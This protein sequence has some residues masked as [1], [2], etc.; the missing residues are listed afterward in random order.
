MTLRSL[1]FV[2]KDLLLDQGLLI[3]DYLMIE[4]DILEDGQALIKKFVSTGENEILDAM[5]MAFTWNGYSWEHVMGE[6]ETVEVMESMTTETIQP[7]YTI[8]SYPDELNAAPLL[9][10]SKGILDKRHPGVGEPM[11]KKQLANGMSVLEV[12]KTIKP[13]TMSGG[14]ILFQGVNSFINQQGA[15]IIIDGQQAGDNAAVLSSIAPT[16]VESINI[17][18]NPSDIQKHTGLNVVGIIEITIK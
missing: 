11:Y 4:T 14:K 8:L 10:Y 6:E 17:S 7:V 12:I 9:E 5:L 13:F 2:P 18:T 3:D 16:E 1:A 15:L